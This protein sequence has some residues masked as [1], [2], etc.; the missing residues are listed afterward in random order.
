MTVDNVSRSDLPTHTTKVFMQEQGSSAVD[1]TADFLGFHDDYN[2][3]KLEAGVQKLIDEG[4][5]LREF[6][7]DDFPDVVFVEANSFTPTLQ[8]HNISRSTQSSQCHIFEFNGSFYIIYAIRNGS[9]LLETF[10]AGRLESGFKVD[11]MSDILS[12]IAFL[13]GYQDGPSILRGFL[14]Y[15][16]RHYKGG[17][18][19]YTLA[20]GGSEWFGNYYSPITCI[21]QSTGSGKSRLSNELSP[22]ILP[23]I[24]SGYN[25]TG[26]P[27]QSL[28]L[29][30][31]VQFML[32][33]NTFNGSKPH[34]SCIMTL[35]HEFL[36]RVLFFSIE[37][38]VR[39]TRYSVDWSAGTLIGTSHATLADRAKLFG[40]PIILRDLE[41]FGLKSKDILAG[42]QDFITKHKGA[43]IYKYGLVV[44]GIDLSRPRHS[45]YEE[46]PMLT[47][48]KDWAIPSIDVLIKVLEQIRPERILHLVERR[49]SD[50]DIEMKTSEA[51]KE[52]NWLPHVLF[53]FDEGQNLLGFEKNPEDPMEPLTKPGKYLPFIEF[54][55]SEKIIDI[56]RLIRR[57]MRYSGL[58]W[59]YCWA[60]TVSTDISMT[61]FNPKMT[62]QSSARLLIETM[63]I[64][65]YINND[66]YDVIAGDYKAIDGDREKQD[67]YVYL[68]SWKRIRDILSCGRP[69]FFTFVEVSVAKATWES[70]AFC[71]FDSWDQQV[72]DAFTNLHQLIQDKLNGGLVG[73]NL[74]KEDLA[75]SYLVYAL[76][77]SAVGLYGC[78]TNMRKEKLV[79][80][81]MAQIVSFDMNQDTLEIDYPSEGTFNILC[82]LILYRQFHTFVEYNP[83]VCREFFAP[84]ADKSFATWKITGILAR[85]LFLFAHISAPP[86]LCLSEDS[87]RDLNMIYAPR[88]VKDV[89]VR[90]SNQDVVDEF[91]GK[92]GC[93]FANCLTYFGYFEKCSEV[94]DPIIACK[95]MLYRG[96]ARYF[97]AGHTGADLML[98]LVL[99]DGKYGLILVQVKGFVTDLLRNQ[100]EAKEAIKHC[101]T[102]DIFQK[103][104]GVVIDDAQCTENERE[105]Q[106]VENEFLNN[107][108]IIRILI[109]ISSCGG[110]PNN[111]AKVITDGKLPFLIIQTDCSDMEVLGEQRLKDFSK[112]LVSA[113]V[114]TFESNLPIYEAQ[115]KKPP[116][117]C[118]QGKE[119]VNPVNTTLY[120]LDN[121]ENF[122]RTSGSSSRHEFFA[123]R[124]T[125]NLAKYFPTCTL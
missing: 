30:S 102:Y 89:L 59:K 79:C 108:P 111:G 71:K 23:I 120:G 52:L 58:C 95:S 117:K 16:S 122:F 11:P 39:D 38:L 63:L 51:T 53:V 12:S 68:E 84:A 103:R 78:P 14:Y 34:A 112:S 116:T 67:G 110:R 64:P 44:N 56:F 20:A 47:D 13:R 36:R 77:S 101:T 73:S 76:L 19:F 17:N 15:L 31:F 90:L 119:P 66:A 75:N 49:G 60:T 25:A 9:P 105:Q 2:F 10:R 3:D 115:H 45:K 99:N 57:T 6:T 4:N 91:L 32:Q 85:L 29:K 5:S 72:V 104:N 8:L 83:T 121:D 24:L 43:K 21:N 81:R 41:H 124:P 70:Q 28:V 87:L 54:G 98:P 1:L 50:G 93:R 62:P 106:M 88:F 97:P 114:E 65:P 109:N 86:T 46:I 55:E 33:Y 125:Y 118:D 92:L 40:K 26:Y 7:Q 82:C 22:F 18:T 35:T 61:E 80:K 37:E 74:L 100:Y 113:I 48:K 69:L 123:D 96:S 27:K 107:F 94:S 42:F